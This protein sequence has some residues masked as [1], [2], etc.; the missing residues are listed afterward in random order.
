MG[1]IAHSRPPVLILGMHRSGTSMIAR[2]LEELGLFLGWRKQGDHEALFFAELNN[3]LLEQAGGR[4]DH[5][6]AVHDLIAVRPV[7]ELVTDYLDLSLRSPRAISYLGP[8]RYLRHRSAARLPRPWG[9]KDPRTT[10]T[11]PLWQ[12]LFPNARIVNI[13]RHGID[14]AASLRSR[15]EV[16]LAGWRQRY[17][18]LRLSYQ[19][20]AKESSFTTS[21]RCAR[22]ER[23]FSLWEQYMREAERRTA[24]LGDRA[25]TLRYEDFLATPAEVLAKLSE[26]CELDATPA[27]IERAAGRVRANRAYAYRGSEELASF[28]E[29]VEDRLCAYDYKA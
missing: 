20:R 7:R 6:E 10:F 1:V 8:V 16:V 13:E 3:W 28:A 11:L 15:H 14:V 2:L 9:W 29:S 19:L 17:D 18:R 22:L 23:G 21:V 5:P 26:F 12:D 24:G 4:W 27:A 25:L